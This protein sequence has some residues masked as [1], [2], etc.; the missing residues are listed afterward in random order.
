MNKS[1]L[2]IAGLGAFT[3]AVHAE[4]FFDVANVRAVQPQYESVAVPRDE[5]ARQ[6]VTEARPV[7]QRD[8]GG[9]VV[10]GI[11]GA[12]LGNQVGGGHGREAATA[13]GAVVGA[14]TGDNLA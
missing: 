9:A 1:I 5:C 2:L 8:Y 13:I 6:W 11:A 14:M 4:T 10:G 7:A 3:A 12:L